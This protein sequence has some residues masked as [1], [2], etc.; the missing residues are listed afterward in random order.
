MK[1]KPGFS[2]KTRSGSQ[3]SKKVALA[4]IQLSLIHLL[5]LK[6][7]LVISLIW[8]FKIFNSFSELIQQLVHNH[9]IFFRRGHLRNT[10]TIRKITTMMLQS[11]IHTMSKSG[12][13]SLEHLHTDG[14]IL[15][16]PTP[17]AMLGVKATTYLMSS[18]TKSGSSS[19][20]T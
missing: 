18:T 5:K 17:Q 6:L 13:R 3:K 19:K 9:Y 1:Y 12:S 14:S 10:M 7:V 8:K 4:E 16:R 15:Q 20:A 11:R 2:K